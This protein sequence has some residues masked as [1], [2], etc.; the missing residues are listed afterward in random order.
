MIEFFHKKV[1][2]SKRIDIIA[3]NL[4]KYCVS[5]TKVLD[6]GS[7][8]G[9]VASIIN[10]YVDCDIIGVDVVPRKTN[11]IPIEIYDGKTIPFE[12]SS[13]DTVIFSDVLH[14][15]ENPNDAL[16]EGARV[17]SKRILIKDH[18][19]EDKLD[20]WTLRLMDWVGNS[21]LNVPLPYNYLSYNQWQGIFN[22]LKLNEIENVNNLDLYIIPLQWI[23]GR[24]LHFIACLEKS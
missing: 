16:K 5:N 1:V 23:F 14:H 13:F 4:A 11:K 7:G 17:S 12:D 21:Y 2:Y 8:D 18:L 3:K 24:K 20:Y 9:E 22:N 19:C 6:V 10:Q 15:T